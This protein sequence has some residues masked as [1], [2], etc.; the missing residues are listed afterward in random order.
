M[1]TNQWHWNNDLGIT[2]YVKDFFS[3]PVKKQCATREHTIRCAC[4]EPEHAYS[5]ND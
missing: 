4:N 1:T 5:K 3:G 2:K